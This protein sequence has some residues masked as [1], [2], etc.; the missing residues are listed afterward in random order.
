M[1][2]QL[3]AHFPDTVARLVTAYCTP[4]A[5]ADAAVQYEVEMTLRFLT[6]VTVTGHKGCL[7]G[8]CVGCMGVRDAQH[9]CTH[10]HMLVRQEGVDVFCFSTDNVALA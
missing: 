6:F 1:L 10:R 8:T 4:E 9:L 7:L 3:A 2:D 5:L